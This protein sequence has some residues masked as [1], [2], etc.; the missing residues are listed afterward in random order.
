MPASCVMVLHHADGTLAE[1]VALGKRRR[2]QLG[3]QTDLDMQTS[4]SA[5]GQSAGPLPFSHGAPSRASAGP[6]TG[7]SGGGGLS[8]RAAGPAEGMMAKWGYTPGRVWLCPD[9]LTFPQDS[10][11]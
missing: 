8:G 2:E 7:P 6:L 4:S 11:R 9:L 10:R 1:R 5:A 3:I